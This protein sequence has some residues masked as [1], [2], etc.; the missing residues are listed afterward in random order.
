LGWAA[1]LEGAAFLGAAF[2][3]GSA[4]LGAAFF[5]GC[6]PI[7]CFWGG[8]WWELAVSAADAAGAA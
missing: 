2:F 4:F 6:P 5:E 3:A 7:G 8:A 1:S